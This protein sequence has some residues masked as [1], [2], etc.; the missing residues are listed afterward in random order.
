MWIFC[1]WGRVADG[2]GEANADG[3]GDRAFIGGQ[4]RMMYFLEEISR[5][6]ISEEMNELA[7]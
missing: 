6:C 2:L 3:M 5:K 7:R 1:V 4:K